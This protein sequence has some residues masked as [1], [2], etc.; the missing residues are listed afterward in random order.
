MNQEARIAACVDLGNLLNGEPESLQ[1]AIQQAAIQNTWFDTRSIQEAIKHIG[2]NYLNESKL[3]D[4]VKQ[5]PQ[6]DQPP[7]KVGII[8]A[9]NIPL[10][11]FHDLLTV[12]MAGH[13]SILKL[14][15]KDEVLLPVVLALMAKTDD[16]VSGY[17]EIVEKLKDIDAILATGSNNSARYFEY[18]FGKYPHIIRKNRVGVAVL[19]GRETD[20]ELI[21]LGRDVFL[22]FGLG[23]RNVS[24]LFVPTGYD[25]TRL[26]SLWD[27]FSMVMDNNSYHNNYD[28]NLAI[29]IMGKIN[30]FTN[31]N[32]F[33]VEQ[34]NLASRIAAINYQYYENIPQV[35]ARLTSL[36]ENI[37]VIVSTHD[38]PPLATIRPGTAQSPAL[39]DY[40]DGVDTFQFLTAL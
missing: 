29:Y 21:A 20:E 37:Q 35:L 27:Q 18:Y 30:Y 24:S 25:F 39:H 28:Y 33:L 11:G 9:G 12:F 3:R 23:C 38:L 32:I 26:M 13:I 36:Q 6:T 15:H 14:A 5:Y 1:L 4:W 16:R 19:N 34:P 7:K 2:S 8:M 10:V 22:Y 31:A 40:A 17:F